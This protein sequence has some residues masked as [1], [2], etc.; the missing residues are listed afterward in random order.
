MAN[1]GPD[2]KLGIDSRGLLR[3]DFIPLCN[4]EETNE[5]EL[6]IGECWDGVCALPTEE[7]KWT[8]VTIDDLP[9]FNEEYPTTGG[10]YQD[11][12]LFAHDFTFRSRLDGL[13][14]DGTDPVR[15]FV[16][17]LGPSGPTDIT[18]DSYIPDDIFTQDTCEEGKNYVKIEIILFKL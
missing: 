14:I 13:I 12:R 9:T 11:L 18:G 4:T 15:S 17:T 16:V 10:H 3:P 8:G 2:T 7:H 5:T 1:N 6:V